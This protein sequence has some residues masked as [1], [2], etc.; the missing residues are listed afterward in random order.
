MPAII[1]GIERQQ[2][3]A[4]KYRGHFRGHRIRLHKA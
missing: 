1:A 4:R 3:N 2:K